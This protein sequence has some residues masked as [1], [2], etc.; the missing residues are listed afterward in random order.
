MEC[1]CL[2][3]TALLIRKAV[4]VIHEN[5]ILGMLGETQPSWLDF[6]AGSAEENT[7]AARQLATMVALMAHCFRLSQSSLQACPPPGLPQPH[8]A[9]H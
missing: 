7:V 8:E 4:D 3:R 1:Q 2:E 5:N 9:S 6:N